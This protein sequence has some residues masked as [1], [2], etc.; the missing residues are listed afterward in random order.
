MRGPIC[1]L[2]LSFAFTACAN[3]PL[4]TDCTTRPTTNDF[5]CENKST[6]TIS[7][8]QPKDIDNWIFTS[9]S[10]QNS[11]ENACMNSNGWPKIIVCSFSASEMVF[12]CFNEITKQTTIIT[13]ANSNG[14]IGVSA[15]DEQ[16]LLN[17]CAKRAESKHNKK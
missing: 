5:K 12:G 6:N 2:S 9:A 10:D 8:G 1:L 13:F 16:I 7:I 17:F 3:G 11:I 4:I 15:I 14:L